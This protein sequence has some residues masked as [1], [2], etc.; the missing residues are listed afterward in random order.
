MIKNITLWIKKVFNSNKCKHKYKWLK[1]SNK[2]NGSC[3][4]WKECVKC[5]KIK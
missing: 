3:L 5:G 4:D 2:I 1:D